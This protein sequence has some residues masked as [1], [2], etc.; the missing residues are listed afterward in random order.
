MEAAA[1]AT[2]DDYVV[3]LR[4]GW[5]RYMNSE[6]NKSEAAY[7][8]AIEI[9]RQKSVEALLGLTYPLAAL[10]EWNQVELAYLQILDLDPNHFEANL[11]LGNCCPI[12][13]MQQAPKFT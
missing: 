12:A 10:G 1:T 9:S 2:P 13:G 5:I 7:R 4:L 8:K 11:Y 3:Q 6:F